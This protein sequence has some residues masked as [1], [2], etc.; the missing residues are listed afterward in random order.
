MLEFPI[1]A[2]RQQNYFVPSRLISTLPFR[3]APSSMAIR[4]AETSPI[5]TADLRKSTRSLAKQFPSSLPCTVTPFASTFAF[6]CPFGPIVKS[7]PLSRML[8]S[9]CSSR[10]KSSLPESSPLM[11]TD[12]PICANS[13]VLGTSIARSPSVWVARGRSRIAP[14]GFS[15]RH[16]LTLTGRR[17]LS[18][19]SGVYGV[20]DAALAPPTYT[21]F[22]I[23]T[24]GS[25]LRL[26]SLLRQ[27]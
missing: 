1:P 12:L 8:P 5:T 16:G 22:G 18:H 9:T 7:L 3:Y 20:R 14:H 11:T 25:T 10:Y 13:P 4:L 17:I 23:R 21:T 19:S 15:A 26:L 24:T 27:R 6:T 2:K